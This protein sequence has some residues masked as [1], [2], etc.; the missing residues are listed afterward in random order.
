MGWSQRNTYH[1]GQW[2]EFLWPYS[3]LLVKWIML[4]KCRLPVWHV[5]RAMPF[6]SRFQL[7]Q[8]YNHPWRVTLAQWF[9]DATVIARRQSTVDTQFLSSVIFCDEP[10]FSCEGFSIRTTRACEQSTT[11]TKPDY[12]LQKKFIVNVWKGIAVNSS[13]FEPNIIQPWLYARKYSSFFST[14]LQKA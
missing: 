13:L 14:V 12:K 1:I 8:S 2:Y 9:G 4:R 10:I 3:T 6:I 5:F 7:L 11:R